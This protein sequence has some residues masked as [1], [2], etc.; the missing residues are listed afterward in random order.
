MP[1]VTLEYGEI[2]MGSAVGVQRHL[3][4]IQQNLANT[5]EL[6]EE[7][8]RAWTF[9]IEGALGELV[10]AKFFGLH[11]DGGVNKFSAT[12]F[13]PVQIRT[14]TKPEY[15]L[16]VREKDPD[17]NVF[18]LVRGMCPTYNIVGWSFG[19]DAKN[20]KFRRRWGNRPAAYFVPDKCLKDPES[21]KRVVWMTA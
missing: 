17:D 10:A 15:E 12:D 4:A 9:H 19:R 7:D 1:I 2:V 13:G 6:R 16:I 14:R 5:H 11:W 8:D 21:L 18:L 20:I 3:Q